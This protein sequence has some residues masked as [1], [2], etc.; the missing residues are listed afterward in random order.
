MENPEVLR[1]AHSTQN[2]CTKIPPSH[3]DAL[4]HVRYLQ[5][6]GLLYGGTECYKK[7]EKCG[8]WAEFGV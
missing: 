7:E 6:H 3:N 4:S 1:G 5:E 8:F 2:A